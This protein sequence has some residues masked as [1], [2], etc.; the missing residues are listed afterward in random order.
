MSDRATRLTRFP[1][2]GLANPDGK[3]AHLPSQECLFLAQISVAQFG[4]Q[5]GWI[6]QG[7]RESLAGRAQRRQGQRGVRFHVS[8]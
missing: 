8:G 4:K 3:P 6:G 1:T 2:L 5:A 7:G